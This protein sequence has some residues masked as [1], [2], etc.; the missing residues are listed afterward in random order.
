MAVTHTL[1]LDDAEIVYDV[2]GSLPTADGRPPLL[3]IG[4]P[5]DASGFTALADRFSDRT[6]VTLRPSWTWAQ[7]S[8]GRPS[9]QRPRRPG[10]RCPPPHRGAR[11]ETG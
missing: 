7:R 2:R 10:Q 6:V 11:C 3:M 5:M 9:R 1:V 4:Q 8:P